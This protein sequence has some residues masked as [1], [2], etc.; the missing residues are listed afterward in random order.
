VTAPAGVARAH[1][2]ALVRWP[3]LSLTVDELARRLEPLAVQPAWLDARGR[4]L[5]LAHAS[6]A[7]DPVAVAVFEQELL[8]PARGVIQ[9]YTRD[10][11]RTDEVLQQLRIHLLVADGDAPPRITRFD[12]RA[13]LGAWVAMCAARLALHALRR[14]RNQ[15]EVAIEWSEALAALPAADPVVEQL[16]V[17]HAAR[18]ADAL[19]AACLELPRR[20]RAI[21]RLLFVENATVDEIAAIYAVHRVTVWRWVQDARATLQTRIAAELR[22]LSH[23]DDPTSASLAAWAADQIELSL[24]GALASTATELGPR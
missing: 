8:A 13:A 15:R 14:E 6:A 5:V 11:A 23:A 21:L 22:G 24:D 9:R 10:P 18:F 1:A 4:D 7:G 16:R 12:G 19:R 17:R 20:Q 2:E 3:T